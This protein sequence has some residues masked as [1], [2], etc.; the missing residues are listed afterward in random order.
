MIELVAVIFSLISVWLSTKKNIWGWPIGIIG[1][2]FYF[3][4]FEQ[5]RDWNNMGLQIVFLI[6][7]IYGWFVW[8]QAESSNITQLKNRLDL[9]LVFVL[10]TPFLYFIS[11]SFNG[12]SNLLDSITTCLSL[13][14]MVLLAH[15]KIENWI[16]WAIADFL[17]IGLFIENKLYLSAGLYFI[18]LI[19]AIWGYISWKK[20]LKNN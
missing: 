20:Q 16:L 12:N 11:I 10:L 9:S 7:S 5:G 17:Y 6:Q 19:L 15:K 13:M 8:K 2:I 4:I 3:L 14:G 1:V 18:F